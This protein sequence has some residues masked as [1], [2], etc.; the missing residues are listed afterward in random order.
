MSASRSF[1]LKVE[2]AYEH[3]NAFQAE[4][5]AWI[6]TKPYGIVDEQDPEP[7]PQPVGKGCQ[8]RRFRI[9]R[10]TPVPE[11][12]SLILGDCLFNLR[13]G[14]DHL[15]LALA[16]SHTP[17]MSQTQI[18]QSEFPIFSNARKYA[19][20]ATKKIACVHPAASAIIEAFQP[21]HRGHGYPLSQLHE[22]NRIDKHRALTVCAAL[23]MVN[24]TRGV[25]I[26][27]D[28]MIDVGREYFL[29]YGQFDYELDA[30]W[31]RWGACP[32][33]PNQEVRVNP[34]APIELA[35]DKGGPSPLEPVIPTLQAL[36]Q[37]VRDPVIAQ[38]SKFL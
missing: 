11:Q 4:A 1:D 15:A 27:A 12:L 22:L 35:F 14:L 19:D 24:G 30:I 26:P 17:G 33:L 8:P 31:V 7:P 18:G 34:I 3:L 21:Y 5:S 25:G 9:N 29:T 2:R 10:V 28:D 38:L 37:F 32:R 36:C 16:R 13:S 23:P 20:Q 6:D